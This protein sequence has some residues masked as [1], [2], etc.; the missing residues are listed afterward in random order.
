MAIP[1]V[2]RVA[3]LRQAVGSA[4]AQTYP[5]VEV[6]IGQDPGPQGPDPAVRDWCQTAARQEPRIRYR[7]NEQRLGLAGNWNALAQAATGSFVAIIGDDDRLE[8]TFVERLI[9]A[10][11]RAGGSVDVVFC[12]HHV[13]DGDGKRISGEGEAFSRRYLRVDLPEGILAKPERLAW[14]GAISMSAALV[15]GD[16]LRRFPF[17]D[18]L[19][20]PEFEFFIRLARAGGQFCFVPDYLAEYRVHAGS[21]TSRGLR[22]ER[23]VHYLLTMEV[24]VDVEAA[25]AAALRG[26]LPAAVSRCLASGNTGEARRLMLGRYYPRGEH[27]RVRGMVRMLSA[28]LP[29][30]VG[31][32]FYFSLSRAWAKPVQRRLAAPPGQNE[33][34]S[35]DAATRA[36]PGASRNASDSG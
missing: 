26:L 34:A 9:S 27:L 7:L 5:Y 33:A 35:R 24:P 4:L 6:L 31:R 18:D 21:E 15:R 22:I 8:P 12:N 3:Y 16:A 29:S 10:Q 23:L 36:Q 28:L 25:K 13:I 19:N 32:R 11:R 1:T 30:S 17:R 14:R 2:S 20:T